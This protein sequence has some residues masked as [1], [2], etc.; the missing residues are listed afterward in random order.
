MVARSEE[1]AK[2]KARPH[3]RQPL[4]VF[5]I[6]VVVLEGRAR[7][8]RQ[9]NVDALHLA[10]VERQQDLE[11]FQ[12]VALDEHVVGVWG[13]GG[14]IGGFFEEAIGDAGGVDVGVSR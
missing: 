10:G 1:Q 12:I 13:A 7:V 6:V 5:E 14:K 11:G 4:A 9:I 8:I 3:H 2:H